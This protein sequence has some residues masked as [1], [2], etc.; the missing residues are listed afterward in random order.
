[1]RKNKTIKKPS[2]IKRFCL[3]LAVMWV[4]TGVFSGVAYYKTDAG[5]HREFKDT[6]E[7]FIE[8]LKE[9]CEEY[10][11]AYS[12][13]ELF[14]HT[15]DPIETEEDYLFRLA[16]AYEKL[17]FGMDLVAANT[18]MYTELRVASYDA[19]LKDSTDIPLKTVVSPTYTNGIAAHYIWRAGMSLPDE[20]MVCGVDVDPSTLSF[21]SDGEKLTFKSSDRLS[22]KNTNIEAKLIDFDIVNENLG[23]PLWNNFGLYDPE[24]VSGNIV[25]FYMV[26]ECYVD[27]EN[28]KAI[29]QTIMTFG[30]GEGEERIWT[31]EGKYDISK[32]F[33]S[34]DYLLS[35]SR[36]VGTST[37]VVD[38]QP[39]N[40]LTSDDLSVV[41]DGTTYKHING[42]KDNATIVLSSYGAIEAE[43]DDD[44]DYSRWTLWIAEPTYVTL[45]EAAPGIVIANIALWMIIALVIALIISYIGYVRAKSVYEIVEY[46]RKVTDNM[47]HDLKTPLAAISLYSENLEENINNDKRSYYSSKIRENVIAMNNMIEGILDFSKTES[48]TI[49]KTVSEVSVKDVVQSE[50]DAV[51]DVF[52]KKDLKVNIKGNDVKIK[53]DEKLLRQALRNL[54]S[55]AIKFARPG[56]EVEISIDEAGLK[57][58]NKTDEKIESIKNITK[59]F[60]KGDPSRGSETG[61]GLGLSIVESS[62]EAAGHRFAV[63]K[64]GDEFT[65]KVRW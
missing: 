40:M 38:Y 16:K 3:C 55:N 29:P 27:T 19:K 22:E 28:F 60:I 53:T 12:D 5:M 13:Y 61:S 11:L 36:E 21:D 47:A 62:L 32:Y 54:M 44:I 39:E 45:F 1:M 9:L 63:D 14:K 48:G 59:P 18:G 7:N 56:T 50:Y 10:Y 51:A 17:S 23:F 42:K 58:S 49:K 41:Y 34:S 8:N 37:L 4:I 24:S 46:R 33:F 30:N 25:R 52:E 64:N 65:T 57:M 20:N 35:D 43:L 31:N 15:D 2:F 26:T 6:N